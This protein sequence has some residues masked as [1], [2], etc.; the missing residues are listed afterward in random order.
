MAGRSGNIRRGDIGL[1]DLRC[2]RVPD[3]EIYLSGDMGEIHALGTEDFHE[4]VLLRGI[5]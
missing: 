1:R 3:D 2:I 4:L 5:T